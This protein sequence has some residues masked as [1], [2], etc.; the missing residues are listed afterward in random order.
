MK[1]GRINVLPYGMRG[2]GK[3][4]GSAEARDPLGRESSQDRQETE[5]ALGGHSPAA[6]DSQ[7]IAPAADETA[8]ILPARLPE[9]AD[10]V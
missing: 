4:D 7:I 1:D 10:L 2:R 9:G 8:D 6:A 3:A 5:T